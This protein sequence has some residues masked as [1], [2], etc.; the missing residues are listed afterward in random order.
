[1]TK[2]Y[3]FIRAFSQ[4]IHKSKLTADQTMVLAHLAAH[5]EAHEAHD[6]SARQIGTVLN[7]ADTTVGRKLKELSNHDFV[8]KLP[9]Q[10]AFHANHS[11]IA[12]LHTIAREIKAALGLKPRD[13]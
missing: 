1:M 12:A 10:R 8:D 13:P 5:P 7:I 4:S 3:L 9:G 2:D 11:G 6:R